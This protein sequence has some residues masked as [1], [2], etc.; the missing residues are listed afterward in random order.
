MGS[1]ERVPLLGFFGI[2]KI[3]SRAPKESRYAQTPENPWAVSR[4]LYRCAQNLYIRSPFSL[5]YFSL[6]PFKKERYGRYRELR[7]RRRWSFTFRL[8]KWVRDTLDT[9][10]QS[11]PTP[12]IGACRPTG[13][14][15]SKWKRGAD[16][17]RSGPT[18]AD[19]D[20]RRTALSAKCAR[21]AP[22][23]RRQV[24]RT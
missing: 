14:G 1:P 3:A 16:F 4:I 9:P 15:A 24:F 7:A 12:R 2:S 5:L 17:Q 22:R 10:G 21:R 23:P 19:C 18:C 11:R 8:P 6:I 13:P 20:P